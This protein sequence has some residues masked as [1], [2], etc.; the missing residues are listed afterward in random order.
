MDIPKKYIWLLSV[1]LL[2]AP[3]LMAKSTE[4][5]ESYAWVK[6]GG[7]SH[8]DAPY[9][10]SQFYLNLHY[11]SSI[12]GEGGGAFDC[13]VQIP[14]KWSPRMHVDIRWKLVSRSS[15]LEQVGGESRANIVGIYKAIV[16]IEKYSFP[17]TL[18][19]HFFPGNRVRIISSSLSPNNEKYPISKNINREKKLST[20]GELISTILTE[21]EKNYLKLIREKDLG[22]NNE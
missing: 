3:S 14:F 2:L 18:L 16:P 21:D 5:E 10:V 22:E 19:V 20:E 4:G 7:I 11:Y 8:M 6:I 12:T 13:C 9:D 15:S 17:Q 1:L